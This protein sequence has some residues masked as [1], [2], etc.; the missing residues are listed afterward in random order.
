MRG[1]L[2][3]VGVGPGDP[4]LMTLKAVRII[5]ECSVIAVPSENLES[6]VAYNIAKSS[7]LN[8]EEKEILAV[9]MPMTKDKAVLNAN[10]NQVAEKIKK[11]LDAGQD[12]AML[13]I[14]DPTVYSTYMYVHQRIEAAG[15]ETMIVSGITSFCAAAATL[16]MSLVERSQPLHIY[17]GSYDMDEVF[18]VSGTKV[19][20][21]SARKFMSVKERLLDSNLEVSMV[22][23][24]GLENEKICYGIENFP[25]DSG[26]Y[27]LIVAKENKGE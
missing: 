25:E 22:E 26:Y 10:Y 19:L 18:H 2:Y 6:C 9:A 24:C 1:K 15:Y 5:N 3:G 13:T 4:E 7:V 11:Y 23:N 12:V 8:I 16:N 14:G 27:T 20:M 21:K 17:P